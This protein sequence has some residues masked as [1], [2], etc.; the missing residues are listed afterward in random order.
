MN[1]IY[2]FG[3]KCKS[4][5]ILGNRTQLALEQKKYG[6]KNR[7]MILPTREHIY[8]AGRNSEPPVA[9]NAGSAY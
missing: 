2:D 8:A 9:V 7:I 4:D 5:Y 3:L 6:M 1:A